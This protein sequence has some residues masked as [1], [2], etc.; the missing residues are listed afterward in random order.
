MQNSVRSG[1]LRSS[2]L[3]P[4]WPSMEQ[5]YRDWLLTRP[6]RPLRQRSFLAVKVPRRCDRRT[7]R[8]LLDAIWKVPTVE[9]AVDQVVDDV[10]NQATRSFERTWETASTGER[11]LMVS[12]S[13]LVAGAVPA[14]ILAHGESR[15]MAFDLIED[16]RIPIPGVD[17]LSFRI[18]RRGRVHFEVGVTF[19]VAEWLRSRR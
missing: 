18:K 11:A 1:F 19:D 4:E 6:S 12:Y 15:R 7:C 3:R 10:S 14:P 5:N 17:G 8:D 2:C 16:R 13:A 9:R